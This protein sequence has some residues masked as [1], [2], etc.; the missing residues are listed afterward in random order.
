M[1]I[2]GTIR[3]QKLLLKPLSLYILMRTSNKVGMS[4]KCDIW[5]IS[6]LGLQ[7]LMCSPRF[8]IQPSRTCLRAA[9]PTEASVPSFLIVRSM[10]AVELS[11]IKVIAGFGTQ[12]LDWS[13]A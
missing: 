5:K 11:V 2:D 1:S 6:Y 9:S 13:E 3:C 10:G 4:D 12:F 8:M 7:F